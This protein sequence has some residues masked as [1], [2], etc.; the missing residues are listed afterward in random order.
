[1]DEGNTCISIVA[2]EIIK[3]QKGTLTAV[4]RGRRRFRSCQWLFFFL[5]S[6]KTDRKFVGPIT[7]LM[8]ITLYGISALSDKAPHHLDTGGPRWMSFR[9][10]RVTFRGET[11]PNKGVMEKSEIF[12]SLLKKLDKLERIGMVPGSPAAPKIPLQKLGGGITNISGTLLFTRSSTVDEFSSQ[13]YLYFVS[14]TRL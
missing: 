13:Q 12:H 9:G 10:K 6:S 1:M 11:Y 2:K 7:I 5:G 14:A 3:W 4:F 8:G